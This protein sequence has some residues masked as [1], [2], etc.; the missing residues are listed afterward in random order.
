MKVTYIGHSGF[1]VE[2]SRSVLLFDY[3]K[4]EL[5]QW[6]E[7]KPL[8]VFASH[9]HRDHFNWEILTRYGQRPNVRFFFGNDIRLGAKWLAQRGIDDSVREKIYRLSGGKSVRDKLGDA[10]ISVW[11]LAS[12]DAGVAFVAETEGKRIYHAG[13]L[14]WWHWES[15]DGADDL[16]NEVM[17]RKYREQIDRLAGLFFDAAFVP[18]D[19][20]LQDSFD[21]GLNYFLEKTDSPAVFPMH[22]W[23]EAETV[24]RYKALAKNAIYADR[25][26]EVKKGGQTWNL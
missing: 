24:S 17:G 23:G 11:T 8:F 22:M 1:S 15:G 26:M 14:N 2:L 3:E 18:L 20:R 13:D 10:G 16:E 25:V 9:S 7:D 19:P 12:T 6:E 21:L 5:P 4:G